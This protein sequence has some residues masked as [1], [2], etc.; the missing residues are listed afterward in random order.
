MRSR[1][2]ALCIAGL[3]LVALVAVHVNGGGPPL[4]EGQCLPA[5]YLLLGGSPAPGSAS[6]TYAATDLGSTQE[7]VTPETPAPQAQM[8]ITAGTLATVPGA[9]TVSVSITPVTPPATRPVG[10]IES[11]VYEFAAI[12]GSQ[13]VAVAPGHPVTITLESTASGG[14]PLTIEHFDGVRW[15]PLKT[16]RGGCAAATYEATTA[17]LG[18]FALVGTESPAPPGGVSVLLVLTLGCLA[19]ALSA[20]AVAMARRRRRR[21]MAP[22]R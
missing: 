18:M 10:T 20:A 6:A 17:T 8:I 2:V 14:A 19:A 15:T 1:V 9:A 11:N 22:G 7:L 5:A 4:Y 21:A 12:S 16:F 13:S 3:S